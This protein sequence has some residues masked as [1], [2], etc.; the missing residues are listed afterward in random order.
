MDKKYI[1][2]L[3]MAKASENE[4]IRL[5]TLCLAYAPPEDVPK[6]AEI[7]NDE[8]D[9]DVILTDLL[10]IVLYLICNKH[11]NKPEDKSKKG[12]KKKRKNK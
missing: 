3:E 4:A 5:Y 12:C 8:N 7:M 6:L 11:I 2:V 10:F 1:K 9:H